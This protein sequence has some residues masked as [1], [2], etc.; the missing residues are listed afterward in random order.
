M[1]QK[2]KNKY[3][4]PSSR[5]QNWDYG[6]NGAYFITICTNNRECYFG[7]IIDSKLEASELGI[8]AEKYWLDIPE[9]FPYVELGNFVIMPNH[10]HGILIIDKN[11]SVSVETRLIASPQLIASLPETIYKTGG[12]AGDKN[13]MLH[14]NI[15]KIIRWYKGRCS[16]E[17][18]KIHA[19]FGWQP[20]FHDHIIRNEKSFET[21]QN[22]IESNPL[23]WN[24]DKFYGK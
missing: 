22:Y 7:D 3:R 12:F 10:V 15:S 20:R 6:A 24:K 18:K 14:D 5:L 23:N 11:A 9:H 8:L 21:I 17:M 1:S 16:F 19:D 2:F 13:P 4:I